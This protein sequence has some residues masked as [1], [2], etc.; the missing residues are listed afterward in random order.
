VSLNASAS[1]AVSVSGTASLNINGGLMVNSNSSSAVDVAST[2]SLSA[3]SL[4]LNSGGG[5]LIG[6][7]LNAVLGLLGLGLGG[8]SP[9]PTNYGPPVADPLR[10]LP[11]PNP[12]QLGLTVQGTN[13]S[14]TGGT[15][16]LYPGIYNGG[17][18]ISQGASVTLHP[19][20]DG[21]PGIYFLQG[22]GLNVSGPSSLT[23]VSGN[24]AGVMIYNNW[25]SSSDVVR[26]A[27]TGSTVLAPPSS[28]AY[29]G[30]TIFQERGTSSNPAPTLT[31]VGSN[32]TNITGT[33][34]CAYSDVT[35]TGV[36]GTSCVGGQVIADTVQARGRGTLNI[37]PSSN[38]TAGSRTF[39]LVE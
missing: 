8:G 11:A 1:A 33:I 19:N 20:A 4:Y 9:P 26:L 5:G 7:L 22:G 13:L 29:Q 24:T 3:T 18:T 17:I 38:P 2:A 36:G 34:Y 25:Q 14:I 16:D 31:I 39:G 6:T 15:A 21:S 27:G 10:S 12:T 28:G 32:N 35:L 30:L 23:V 37:D